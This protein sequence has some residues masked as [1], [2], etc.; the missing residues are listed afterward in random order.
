MKRVAI[1]SLLTLFLTTNY[2]YAAFPVK[3]FIQTMEKAQAQQLMQEDIDEL[4]VA[5]ISSIASDD[6][7]NIESL[8]LL[9]TTYCPAAAF[10]YVIMATLL[11]GY[12]LLF[13]FIMI[14][15]ILQLLSVCLY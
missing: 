6:V 1:I 12:P 8:Q 10:V 14:P 11:Q 15:A 4:Y 2:A 5:V 13:F 9:N 3:K 7:Q